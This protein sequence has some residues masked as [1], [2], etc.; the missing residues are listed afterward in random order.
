[1]LNKLHLTDLPK[2][3]FRLTTI[4]AIAAGSGAAAG[5]DILPW[6]I[7]LILP[8]MLLFLNRKQRWVSSILFC[9]C[10]ISGFICRCQ[11][12]AAERKKPL[13][14]KHV[15][16]SLY[17]I[18]R[19]ITNVESLAPLKFTRCMVQ[20][21][22]SEF[23]ATVFMPEN[24]RLSYGKTYTFSGRITP[25]LPAGAVAGENGIIAEIPPYYGNNPTVSV[26]NF[27]E[28]GE[29]FS[30][31]NCFFSLRDMA[32]RRLTAN[33]KDPENA[34]M[35]AQL[36]FSAGNGADKEHRQ[37][38]I[39]TGTI[40]LFSVS[41]LHVS[42]LSVIILTMLF[43]LPFAWRYRIAA[44]LTLIYVLCTGASLPA[45]RAGAMIIIWAVCRSFM[46][47]VSAWDA[48]MT[49]WC[50]FA[51][52]DPAGVNTI[53]AQYSFGV[54]AALLLLVDLFRKRTMREKKRFTMMPNL[55][56][57]TITL[58]KK[59]KW[60]KKVLMAPA[61]ATV[62][63]AAGC[64]ISL[65]RQ[66]LFTPGSI[67]ANL[68]L[69]GITPLLFIA[70]IMKMTLGAL[71]QLTDKL[72]ALLLEI[73]FHLLNEIT[74]LASEAFHPLPIPQPPL[75]SI[76]LFY[77][78]FFGALGLKSHFSRWSCGI[79]ALAIIFTVW[80][81]YPQSQSDRVI[82]ISGSKKTPPLIAIISPKGNC[83]I[84]NI[85][86]KSQAKLI[87]RKLLQYGATHASV[88]FSDGTYRNSAGSPYLAD[89]IPLTAYKPAG[90][91]KQPTESFTQTLKHEN[92][93]CTGISA[94]LS[95]KANKQ[96]EIFCR[97][98][99]GLEITTTNTVNG[100]YVEIKTPEGKIFS[101]TLPWYHYPVIREYQL[102]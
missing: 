12:I 91:R 65:Y 39:E 9:I 35:A 88:S 31:F 53:S 73:S 11:E 60:Q 6:Y 89:K 77:L 18:D 40:H 41:G 67:P 71:C 7:W 22:D 72:C 100:R 99:E 23:E 49:V 38:F 37:T 26:I 95:I 21:N 47:K 45:V 2:I 58:R 52:I 64:G 69:L 28:S 55:H 74:A 87:S 66:S 78:L 81:V 34:A 54:T 56:P 16:G 13:Y 4:A 43:P 83:R 8:F 25:A 20:T 84:I 97:T 51:I 93:T 57:F 75:W 86:N 19:R 24:A 46:L 59:L 96:H 68:L 32:L 48:M 29:H 36:F 44:L 50:A 76:L 63:F 10:L 102:E 98:P 61:A 92:I 14:Y 90:Q 30:I 85:P 82:I 1:M 15:S 3:D 80:I 79:G 5:R 70:M 101:S 27:T 42:L 17:V 62:A 33:I 94:N